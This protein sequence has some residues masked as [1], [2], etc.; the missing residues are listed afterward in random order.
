MEQK[1]NMNYIHDQNITKKRNS[2]KN[3]QSCNTHSVGE[4]FLTQSDLYFNMPEH[5][6]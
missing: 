2:Y 4:Y 1:L 3:C 6:P 5:T